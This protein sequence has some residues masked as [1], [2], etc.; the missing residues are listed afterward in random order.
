MLKEKPPQS[1]SSRDERLALPIW[2]SLACP[3][4]DGETQNNAKAGGFEICDGSSVSSRWVPD[5]NSGAENS[6]LWV[7]LSSLPL[8]R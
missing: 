4:N 8:M 3:S 6:R 7:G 1:N 2:A 5:L